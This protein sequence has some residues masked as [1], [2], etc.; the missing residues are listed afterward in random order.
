[1]QAGGRRQNRRTAV[2]GLS[3]LYSAMM[4]SRLVLGVENFFGAASR[5]ATG[6]DLITPSQSTFTMPFQS[7]S[8]TVTV[9][10]AIE[11]PAFRI[12]NLSPA[13]HRPSA[14]VLSAPE[15]ALR[16]SEDA[17]DTPPSSLLSRC[18]RLDVRASPEDLPSCLEDE[19]LEERERER[20]DER[21]EERSAAAVCEE[22]RSRPSSLAL[23]SRPDAACSCPGDR[24]SLATARLRR[25]ERRLPLPLLRGG[26]SRLGDGDGDG[27]EFALVSS[28]RSRP[29]RGEPSPS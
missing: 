27:D 28:A 4:A 22:D 9:L 23:L 20:R 10:P 29:I 5:S 17:S 3:V 6:Y 25:P 24:S 16:L 21:E 12:I 2:A 15:T 14:L 11:L 26:V 1:M 19:V 18:E 8:T 13:D 7:A